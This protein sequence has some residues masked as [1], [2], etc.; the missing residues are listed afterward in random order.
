M[1]KIPQRD[2]IWKHKVDGYL[3]RIT[4]VSKLWVYFFDNQDGCCI[5]GDMENGCDRDC[6]EKNFVFVGNGK[7]IDVLFE[8][9][10]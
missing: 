5:D 7:P 1:S 6:F 3:A 8:V 4:Y 10:E 2:E 9:Q